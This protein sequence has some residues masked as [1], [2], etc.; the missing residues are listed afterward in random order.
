MAEKI[1]Q[2][3]S[4]QLIGAAAV[5]TICDVVT[6]YVSILSQS[7]LGYDSNKVLEII[8]LTKI[9][10]TIPM[11]V[12]GASLGNQL[13]NDIIDHSHNHIDLIGDSHSI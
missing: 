3:G 13:Y 8:G 1:K 12:L 11:G 6:M 5:I 2:S 4:A 7:I 9:I 10:S